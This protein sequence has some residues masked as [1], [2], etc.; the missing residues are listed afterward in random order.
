MLHYAD[1][2]IA[3]LPSSFI[4]WQCL[5]AKKAGGINDISHYYGAYVLIM[6][7][8]GA[9]RVVTFN[10]I[11]KPAIDHRELKVVFVIPTNGRNLTGHKRIRYL[12][13][14]R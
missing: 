11:L 10:L 8:G 5:L 12:L 4:E 6:G 1:R 2:S 9:Y 13:A 7:R 14:S 3:E